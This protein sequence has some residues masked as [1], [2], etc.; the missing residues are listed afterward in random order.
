LKLVVV[1]S[2]AAMFTSRPAAAFPTL[3]RGPV[4]ALPDPDRW[5]AQE[6]I[7]TATVSRAAS[8]VA[9]ETVWFSP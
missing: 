6:T 9:I 2:R 8:T 5:R 7:G 1:M 3:I 4:A